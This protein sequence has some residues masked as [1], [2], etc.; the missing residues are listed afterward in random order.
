MRST[1]NDVAREA[2]VSRGTVDRVIN[3]KGN[4]SKKSEEKVFAAI[5]KLDYVRSPF[6]SALSKSGN[7][8][9]I[10]IV[11]PDLDHYYWDE[12][13]KGIVE[14][15]N[16][17]DAMGVEIL[18]VKTK[19]YDYREQIREFENLVQKGV[20]GIITIAYHRNKL[21][22]KIEELY[23]KD[24]PIITFVSDAPDSKR[25]YYVGLNDYKAGMT[26]GKLM[27]LYLEGR[28]NVAV[29]GVHRDLAS[30]EDRI[31]G[32]RDKIKIEYPGIN[33]LDVYSL[34]EDTRSGMDIYNESLKTLT[35]EIIEKRLDINGIYVTSSLTG[36]VGKV[37][38][39]ME[40]GYKIILI[41]HENTKETR[42]MLL[43]DMVHATVFQDQKEEIKRAV[44]ILW[45][46]ITGD[47]EHDFPDFYS[48][49]RILIKEQIE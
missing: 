46:H 21:D 18:T 23:E 45:K 3:N 16:T 11:Y 38:E 8:I 20:K 24:I 12:V 29:I 28:G 47:E 43:N 5:K 27:G 34:K 44:N 49:Q 4:V 39:T 33:I 7:R 30:M 13:D 31:R 32:F 37:L 42:K 19:S 48:K 35:E 26:G 36:H 1:I 41:G 9:K 25:L 15:K 14:M 40:I 6:A 22:K 2:G 10:G 17:M